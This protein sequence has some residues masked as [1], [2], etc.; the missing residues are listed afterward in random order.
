MARIQ[1]LELPAEE[2]ADGKIVTPFALILDQYDDTHLIGDNHTV[3]NFTEFARGCGARACLISRQAIDIPSLTAEEIAT[4]NRAHVGTATVDVVP[5]LSGFEKAMREAV[6][7]IAPQKI[8]VYYG[9]EPSPEL[10]AHR[11]RRIQEFIAE[12]RPGNADEVP[13]RS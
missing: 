7:A 4:I 2:N 1:I 5:D 12:P 3:A 8:S 11:A 9:E 13:P 10:A 6:E